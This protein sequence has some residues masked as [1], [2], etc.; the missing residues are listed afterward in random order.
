MVDAGVYKD[1]AKRTNGEMY[2]GV[3]GAVR[4]GKSTFIRKFM[5]SLVIPN[6]AN[7]FDRERAIDEMPQSGSGKTVMTTEPK[8][9]P[10]E[11]VEVTM[12]DAI[13]MRMKLIDCVGYVVPSA[14]GYYEDEQPRLVMTPW[15]EKPMKFEEASKFGTMKV[16]KE[17]ST[18]AVAITADGSFGEL[19]REDYVSAEEEIVA[20]LKKYGKPFVL[21][22][23]SASPE[24]EQTINLAMTLEDKYQA[25]VA[26]VNCQS[27]N[28]EDIHSIMRMILDEFPVK[29]LGFDL[30]AWLTLLEE[31][32]PLRKSLMDASLQ[33]ARSIVNL[34]DVKGAV[35]YMS[36]EEAIEDASVASIDSGSGAVR[37]KVKLDGDVFY[38]LVSEYTGSTI[39][40]EEDLMYSIIE[41]S[42]QKKKFDSVAAAL[43]EVENR[44]Y[45]IIMPDISELSLDEPEIV[46]RSGSYGV[47]LKASAPSIHMIKANIETEINPVVGTEQQSEELVS[48]LL[49]EFE[50]DPKSIWNSNI[51]GKSLHEL[52]NEGLHTKLAHMP[53]DARMK[54]GETLQRI[55]N[56]GSGGLICIIL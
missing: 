4:T 41:L 30:P 12:N 44:G 54:L 5:E 25:P 37:V 28:T 40:D 55:I 29:E 15:S 19:T 9:I 32:S 47:R 43:T 45:G 7:P 16:I 1:I 11:A 48:Y 33:C 8:F 39:K 10:D 51:F 26:L 3:V 2:V 6:I 36:S 24:S 13:S 22:I 23:N 42:R 38:Q 18:V 31:E 35:A 52:V 20:D 27:L 49:H 34:A 21:V 46:K 53:D 17:H 56:E 14:L 50:E